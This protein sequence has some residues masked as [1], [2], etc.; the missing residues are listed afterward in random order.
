M[1]FTAVLLTFLIAAFYVQETPSC[2]SLCGREGE[3]AESLQ[4]LGG[5]QEWNKIQANVRRQKEA[6]F[7]GASG[8]AVSADGMRKT[9]IW[10]QKCLLRPS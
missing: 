8:A 6:S 5:P 1:V 10:R 2:L 9:P 4:W 3:A 7:L